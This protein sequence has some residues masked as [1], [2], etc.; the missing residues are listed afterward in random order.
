MGIGSALRVIV[1]V[2]AVEA[3]SGVRSSNRSQHLFFMVLDFHDV[4]ADD[5]DA[6][7]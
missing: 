7:A 1:A 6:G 2:V 4:D 3:G 5:D